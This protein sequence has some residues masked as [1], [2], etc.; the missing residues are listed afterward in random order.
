VPEHE[1]PDFFDKVESFAIRFYFSYDR[2]SYDRD[3]AWAV[4]HTISRWWKW[5]SRWEG[6]T[7][8]GAKHA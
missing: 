8:G 1:D 4:T 6:T 5:R 3:L 2:F 7:R